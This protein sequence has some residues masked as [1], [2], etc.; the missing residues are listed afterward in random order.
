LSLHDALPIYSIIM[1]L[2]GIAFIVVPT[3]L[4]VTL[5]S[6]IH[7]VITIR[8]GQNRSCRNGLIFAITFHNTHIR[9]VRLIIKTVTVNQQHLWLGGKLFHCKIHCMKG[10]AQD[11]G[12]VNLF[13]VHLRHCPSQ[14]IAFY[15][16]AQGVTLLFGQLLGVV[17]HFVVIPYRQ[18]N[19]SSIDRTCQ[20][21]SSGFITASFY[22]I[23]GIA[24]FKHLF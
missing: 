2:C 17:E 10:G 5:V 14:S 7:K 12:I 11:I 20:A 16:S 3:I 6:G 18:N 1:L 4:W 15:L 8:F 21:A 22:F 24:F 13:V 19:S 23:E 9:D